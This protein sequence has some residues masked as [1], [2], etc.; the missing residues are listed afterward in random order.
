MPRCRA[1]QLLAAARGARARGP[2]DARRQSRGVRGEVK[3]ASA[4][5]SGAAWCRV[6]NVS[7]QIFILSPPHRHVL[8]SGREDTCCPV[9]V[10]CPLPLPAVSPLRAGAPFRAIVCSRALTRAVLCPRLLHAF[11]RALSRSL[12]PLLF[13]RR[14]VFIL[15][16]AAQP[17]PLFSSSSTP[18]P[19]SLSLLLC[20]SWRPQA[21]SRQ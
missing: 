6:Q 21:R 1:A 4:F 10:S 18:L 15:L 8:C 14:T 13:R 5:A 2:Q 3:R 20:P 11:P 16:S 9:L 7:V 12:S 19:L 17:V